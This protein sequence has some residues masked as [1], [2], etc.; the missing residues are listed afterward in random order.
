MRSERL[1]E[2]VKMIFLEAEALKSEK[3][4]RYRNRKSEKVDIQ[5]FLI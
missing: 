1:E 5:N 4:Y 2:K 3:V